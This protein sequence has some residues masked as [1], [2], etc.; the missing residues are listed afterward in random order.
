M[1]KLRIVRHFHCDIE[2]Q[3]RALEFLLRS[4]PPCRAVIEDET[5]TGHKHRG[6]QSHEYEGDGG[7]Q[8]MVCDKAATNHGAEA[9]EQQGKEH[10]DAATHRGNGQASPFGA[11]TCGACS[12]ATIPI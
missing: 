4:V 3:R 7:P 6:V 12:P 9:G 10:E 11:C 8:Q 2:A 5:M 1:S